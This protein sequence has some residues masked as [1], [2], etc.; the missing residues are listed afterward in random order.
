M[1]NFAGSAKNMDALVRS[2]MHVLV[3]RLLKYE[4]P[5]VA[6]EVE[7]WPS[8]ELLVRSGLLYISAECFAPYS[9][10]IQPVSPKS[11]KKVDEFLR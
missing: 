8:L 9:E 11:I 1:V 10:M 5:I 6:N 2:Q 7:G 4:K 3:E